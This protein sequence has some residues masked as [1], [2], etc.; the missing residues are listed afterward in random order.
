MN[1][2]HG[3]TRRVPVTVAM[4]AFAVYAT[5][6][7]SAPGPGDACEFTLVLATNG[8]A[9]PTGY[10]LYTLFGHLFCVLLHSIGFS[11]PLA[12]NLWSAVGAAVAMGF[13][14]ALALELTEATGT[15]TLARLLAVLLPVSLFAFQPLVLAEATVAEVNSW[16]LAWVGGTG[17]VFLRLVGDMRAARGDSV[18]H[19][20]RAAAR[21][22][23]LCGIGLAHHLTSVLISIPLSLGLITMLA[24]RRLLSA[25]SF[26]A[27]AG[28]ALLPLASYMWVV[29]HAWHPARVQWPWLEPGLAGVVAHVTGAQYRPFFGS[30]APSA[31]QQ[32][33][34]AG[35]AYPFLFP[36]LA[37]LVL[38]LARA[39]DV[40]RRIAWSAMLAAAS[41]VTIFTFRYGVPDPASY[42][43]PAI[44]L[45]VV[46]AAPAILANPRAGTRAGTAALGVAGLASLVLIVPWVRE[47]DERQAA[48]VEFE[49]VIRSMWSAVPSDT[50]IVSWTDDRF[51]LLLGYQILRGEKPAA[52]VITPDLLFAPSM[53]HTIRERFGVDP[54]E[55]FRA[56]R[57][58]LGQPEVERVILRQTRQQLVRSLNQRIRVPVVLFDPSVPI[59]FQLRKPWEPAKDDGS[60]PLPSAGS[61]GHTQPGPGR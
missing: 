27:A 60:K 47:G 11:W 13:L 8:V 33:L 36:G 6:C 43:L 49:K 34:L 25:G 3:L 46:A 54:I 58:P 52:T 14:C 16:S 50:V 20:G 57:L 59:V 45:G 29:W 48:T 2:S 28:A 44:A 7:P 21:W 24:R 30:F 56:P 12:A 18:W 32:E 40:E 38:G 37:L 55:G 1:L 22:G 41:L 51:N 23:L 15:R 31:V 42:F 9:H 19:G 5:L 35:A 17:W 10:P 26:A 4:V 53:R 61:R 39:K